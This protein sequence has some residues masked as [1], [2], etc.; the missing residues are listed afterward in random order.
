MHCSPP[1]SSVHGILQARVLEWVAIPFSRGFFWPRYQTNVSPIAG[2]FFTVSATGKNIC[3][4]LNVCKYS[5]QF[6]N[7]R[8]TQIEHVSIWRPCLIKDHR[9]G[10]MC[11]ILT[12][13]LLTTPRHR[14]NMFW[15]VLIGK[16][17]IRV[18]MCREFI[19]SNRVDQEAECLK[20]KRKKIKFFFFFGCAVSLLL[21]M[22][23]VLLRHVGL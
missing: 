16:R 20:G 14:R 5:K 6:A 10:K 21:H 3:K 19:W 8:E 2:R 1:G 12:F 18:Y 15:V 7:S 17:N 11:N 23:L 9:T 4:Y 22:A 13:A